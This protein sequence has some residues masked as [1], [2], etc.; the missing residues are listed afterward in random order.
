VRHSVDILA[1][2]T[3]WFGG[4]PASKVI[5]RHPASGRSFSPRITGRNPRR[6][7]VACGREIPAAG[8][9]TTVDEPGE[10]AYEMTTWLAEKRKCTAAPVPRCWQ[11]RQNGLQVAD[12][13]VPEPA[14][15]YSLVALYLAVHA[16]HSVTGSCGSCGQGWP[17]E[18][19]RLA[20]RLREG[21]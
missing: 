6:F 3:L 4:V 10:T 2:F 15:L 19:V 5:S 7:T 11:R 9:R 20:Y 12:V 16:A 17:C 18:P 1:S 14:Q 8:C 21:F 13:R